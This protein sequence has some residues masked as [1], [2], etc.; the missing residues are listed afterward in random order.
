MQNSKMS[1]PEENDLSKLLKLRRKTNKNFLMLLNELQ[2]SI[3]SLRI[4]VKYMQFDLEATRRENVV[5]KEQL[6]QYEE[7]G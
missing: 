7:G 3:E 2:T 5:L 4:M 6:R 1:N